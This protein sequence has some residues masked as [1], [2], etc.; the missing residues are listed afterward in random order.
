MT[1]PIGIRLTTEQQKILAGYE[2]GHIDAYEPVGEQELGMD[3][4]GAMRMITVVKCPDD[5]L[6][7]FLWDHTSEESLFEFDGELFDVTPKEVVKTEYV[8][9]DGESWWD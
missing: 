9:D 7:A 2:S 6:R 4:H 8:R 1:D 3:S 5:K